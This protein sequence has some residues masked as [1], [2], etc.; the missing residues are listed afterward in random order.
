MFAYW[1]PKMLRRHPGRIIE[2]IVFHGLALGATFIFVYPLVWLAS[3]SVKPPWEIYR[4][5]LTLRPSEFQWDVYEEIFEVTPFK[6]YL[7]NSMLYSF[8]AGLLT[9]AFAT[10]AAY[11]LSR[12]YFRGKNHLMVA[13]L[14]VQLIPGLLSVIPLYVLMK[15]L[16]LFNTQHGI[17]LLY[18][19][20]QIPWGI[21]VMKGY[22]DTIPIELDEAARIDGASKFRAMIQI[23]M[24]LVVP[25]L[26]ASF[27][28]I[29]MGRWNEFAIANAILTNPDY[30]PLTV[31]TFR[32][33][34]PDEAD[35]RLTAAASL[36][37]IVPILMVFIVLQRFL[38]SG[39]A[40]GAVKH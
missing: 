37:N 24:P 39:L 28:V 12:H 31:G 15:Q 25:G 14:A 5:P 10:F 35:F 2:F 36:I 27:I 17:V 33:L 11:G 19:A 8:G 6:T 4:Q 30:H 32:L 16:G 3:A 13:I 26:A 20:L 21:W 23:I 9:L 22:F 29:F 40:A 18:S 1:S 7:Y 38:V 34:G